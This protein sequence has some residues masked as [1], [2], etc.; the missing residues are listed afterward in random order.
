[1]RHAEFL[2][3]CALGRICIDSDD[4]VGADHARAL[5]HVETDAAESEHRDVR[6]GPDLRGVDHRADAGRHAAADVADLVEGRVLANLRERDLRQHRV[7]GEG[8]AAH[9]VEDRIAV[10]AEA[11]GAVRHQAL[12]LRRADRGAEIGSAGETGFALPAFRRVE[13]DDVIAGLH[14]VTPAPTSRTMPAPS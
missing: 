8:R 13:R 2:S 12:A 10:A 5:D 4:L 3:H 9:V 6:A 11:A 1:M 14:V 7:I